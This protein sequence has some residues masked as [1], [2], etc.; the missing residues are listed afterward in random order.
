MTVKQQLC[1]K[2]NTLTH[3][4]KYTDSFFRMPKNTV[5]DIHQDSSYKHNVCC[6]IST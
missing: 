6:N 2:T 5:Y 3:I 1:H 4:N